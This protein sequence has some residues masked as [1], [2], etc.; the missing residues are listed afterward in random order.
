[1]RLWGRKNSINVQKI[2]WC[3]LEMGMEEG[4]DYE[5]I[6]AGLH[7]GKNHTPE[8]LQLNPNGLVP[9][10]E[11]GDLAL[12]ESNTIMRYL[13]RT[14]DKEGRFP[15]DI[16]SQYESEK[17]MDW[18]LNA[19]WPGLRL[20]FLGLTRIPEADRNYEAIRKQY[21]ES[22]LHFAVL[23][24]TLEKRLFCSGDRFHI[25]DIVL[26]LCVHRWILLQQTFPEQTGP[27]TPL[28]NIDAWLER[29][30][31]QTQFNVFADKQLNI[32]R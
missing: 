15:K 1:M 30:K 19:M 7:F 23:D 9:V 11:D 18:Q 28:S 21:Q 22:N 25:G 20:A 16:V 8:F 13:V 32:V 24:Q 4:K 17:W 12:W 3:L 31:I 6:D 27:R 14:H 2:L 29:I 10:L 5:R 26:A